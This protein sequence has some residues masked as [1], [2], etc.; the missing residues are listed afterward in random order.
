[1]R[2]FLLTTQAGALLAHP[3]GEVA[4]WAKASRF[5]DSNWLLHPVRAVCEVRE[6]VVR[7]GLASP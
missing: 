3:K 5:Y 4:A 1:M 6:A 7:G 2:Q